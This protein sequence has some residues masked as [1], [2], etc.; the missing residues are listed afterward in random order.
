ME[1]KYQDRPNPNTGS[2]S[3]HGSPKLV[4][5]LLRNHQKRL[6]S[7]M[8]RDRTLSARLTGLFETTHRFLGW[9]VAGEPSSMSTQVRRAGEIWRSQQAAGV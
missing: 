2:A 7:S 5:P 4:Q 8:N 9:R 1:A 3:C 6:R